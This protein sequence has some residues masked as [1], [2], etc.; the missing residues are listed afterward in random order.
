MFVLCLCNSFLCFLVVLYCIKSYNFAFVVTFKFLS[1][2]CIVFFFLCYHF[3]FLSTSAQF[4]TSF[5]THEKT[6]E[7]GTAL[8]RTGNQWCVMGTGGETPLST[9]SVQMDKLWPFSQAVSDPLQQVDDDIIH[10]QMRFRGPEKI[11]PTASGGPR[12]IPPATS[13]HG[14][15]GWLVRSP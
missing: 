14:M 1:P 5:S 8:S 9:T 15:W 7:G 12:W 11:S 10:D 3:A 6:S 2:S 4:S 13:S